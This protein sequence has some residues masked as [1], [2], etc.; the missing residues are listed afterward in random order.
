MC[1]RVVAS[2]AFMLLV[3]TEQIRHEVKS[4]QDVLTE[5]IGVKRRT[6]QNIE[7]DFIQ[8]FKTR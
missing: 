1:R 7:I 3:F 2:F 4:T 6:D 8:D 5:P